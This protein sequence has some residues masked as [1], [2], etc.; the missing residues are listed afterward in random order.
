MLDMSITFRNVPLDSKS[1]CFL[2][3]KAE[4]PRTGQVFYFAGKCLPFGVSISCT[5]FQAFSDA[6]AHPVTF[7]T[8]KPL[9]N[10]LDDFFFA[11]LYKAICGGQMYI[12]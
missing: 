5:I 12:F 8:R 7:R 9:V 1:W 11:A 2:V 6:T 4:H 3:L 10:C